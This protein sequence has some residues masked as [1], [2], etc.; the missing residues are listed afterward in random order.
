MEKNMRNK[1]ISTKFW[2]IVYYIGKNTDKKL[3]SIGSRNSNL[4]KIFYQELMLLVVYN[5]IE[6]FVIWFYYLT[7]FKNIGYY[8]YN[9][10]TYNIY[11]LSKIERS[12]NIGLL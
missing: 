8:T 1:G 12:R 9:K 7:H 5:I 11:Q 3:A 6:N 10:K 2:Q 4:F